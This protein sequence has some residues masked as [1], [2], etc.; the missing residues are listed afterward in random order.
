MCL[1]RKL[2]TV[3]WKVVVTIS[4]SAEGLQVSTEHEVYSQVTGDDRKIKILYNAEDKLKNDMPS[5]V[6]TLEEGLRQEFGKDWVYNW[7]DLD[8]KIYDFTNPVFTRTGDLVFE[9]YRA[10]T[11][12]SQ[13]ARVCFVQI[14]IM[15]TQHFRGRYDNWRAVGTKWE[16]QK[17]A[18]S[19]KYPSRN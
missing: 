17:W 1:D 9:V 7:F 4:S 12:N 13:G 6:T 8:M 2:S 19:T 14:F 5:I 15:L 3:W 11:A 16:N 10:H 18:E